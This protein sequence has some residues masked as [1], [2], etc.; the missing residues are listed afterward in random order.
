MNTQHWLL[1]I[2]WIL[3]G[4]V[5]SFLANVIVK[6]SIQKNMGKLF[7]Y[8]RI[9]YSLFALVTLMLL[10]WYQFSMRSI[11]LYS[12]AIIRYGVSLIFIVPGIIIMVK[13]IRKYFF[14]LSGIQ[15]FQKDKPAINYTLQ[16]TGLHKYVRHP[17]YFG[18]LLFVWG[19]FLLF[20]LLSNLIAAVILTVYVV[21]GIQLEETKLFLEYGE[22][23]KRYSKR[24]PK[25]IPKF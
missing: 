16:Q 1:L 4:V 13:C 10:L 7:R 21:I 2:L 5:H 23:Y 14:D 20:P 6:Q 9:C 3:Y 25:L 18:T 11:W 17:L 12:L 8:Y 24:V 19:L 15:S 22:E